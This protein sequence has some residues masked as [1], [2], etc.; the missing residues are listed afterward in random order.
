MITGRSTSLLIPAAKNAPPI[1][2]ASAASPIRTA[3]FTST[4]ALRT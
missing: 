2:P 1:E 4:G 3:V